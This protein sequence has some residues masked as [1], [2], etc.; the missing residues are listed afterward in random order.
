MLYVT[1]PTVCLWLNMIS[2]PSVLSLLR[3]SSGSFAPKVL[4]NAC[5]LGLDHL[6]AAHGHAVGAELVA[7]GQPV[8]YGTRGIE[9]CQDLLEGVEQSAPCDAEDGKVLACKGLDTVLGNGARAQGHWIVR[10]LAEGLVVGDK[11]GPL[12]FLRQGRCHDELVDLVACALDA[13]GMVDVHLGK[14]FLH[15]RE[16]ALVEID[17]ELGSPGGDGKAPRHGHFQHVVYLAKVRVLGTHA[18]GHGG[19]DLGQR[20][21]ELRDI[22]RSVGGKLVFDMVADIVEHRSQ[23]R[24]AVVGELA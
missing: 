19:V 4:G 1:S 15:G 21:G 17:E 12:H 16:Q 18:V 24:I 5:S 20:Q 9:A 2:I 3:F 6:Q 22:A 8:G 7:V 11:Q 10:V 13:L 14:A 23:G